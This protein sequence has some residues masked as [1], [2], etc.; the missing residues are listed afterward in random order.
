M[1]KRQLIDR[2]VSINHTAEPGFLAKFA[3]NQ[4]DEYLQHLQTAQIPR[5]GGDPHRFDHYFDDCPS[6]AVPA[7]QVAMMEP[8]GDAIS[9]APIE[10]IEQDDPGDAPARLDLSISGN[11]L[12]SESYEAPADEES[13]DRLPPVAAMDPE[14]GT[15]S[16]VPPETADTEDQDDP[17]P[18]LD[19]NL[20]E[21]ALFN[22]S[23]E[24]PL[25]D[26]ES[27]EQSEMAVSKREEVEEASEEDSEAW[28]Y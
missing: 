5:L 26:E 16:L 20:S 1:T 6:I 12:L 28:L 23:Y 14:E 24:I 4:L 18:A 15:I 25:A 10:P 7:H 8:E 13:E 17:S 22:E 27:E 21:V 2:I 3:D 19:L 11:D 9:L